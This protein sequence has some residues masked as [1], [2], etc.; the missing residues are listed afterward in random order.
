VPE[1][2]GKVALVTGGSRGIGR[3]CAVELG[4]RGATVI[5]NYV[6]NEDAAQA[7]AEAVRAAG[8]AA[9]LARFD[10][11]DSKAVAAGVKDA[12][13]AHGGIHLCVNSAGIAVDG[14]MMRFK[15]EDLERTLRVNL[16]GTFF[17]GREVQKV[18]IRQKHGRI[19][20]LTSVVGERG[21]GGQAAYASS[22]A[23]VIGLTKS[24]AQEL[25]SRNILVNAVSPGYIETDMTARLEGEARAKL[26]DVIPLGRTGQPE[27]VAVVVAFLCGDGASYIT[28]Q[29]IRVNGG[30]YV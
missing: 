23:G 17:V 9:A 12:A 1:L 8:G 28:G 25:A 4:R 22:K 26:M 11:A 18:M 16:M 30:M 20:N 2:S 10:V 24:M 3:A 15:D 6:S 5:V 21:N 14:L 13:A 7:A 29:V 19:V 27:E